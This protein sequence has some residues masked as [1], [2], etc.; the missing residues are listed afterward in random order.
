[1]PRRR[2]SD[3]V[4]HRVELGTWERDHLGPLATALTAKPFMVAFTDIIR[5]N[6]ALLVIA[7]VLTL[8]LPNWLPPGW[9]EELGIGEEG[10]SIG[11][12]VRDWLETQNL[13]GAL[14]GAWGGAWAGSFI[15]GPGTLIGAILGFF[16]G[17]VAVEVGEDVLAELEEQQ[18]EAQRGGQLA[19]VALLI[20]IISILER[21]G[22]RDS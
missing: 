19:A 10:G 7:G 20:S 8:L 1:M 17:L 13:V 22:N 16:S 21:V 5:D 2:P 6:S 12:T 9:R 3:V 4:V 18:Q 11:A 14:A 15:P